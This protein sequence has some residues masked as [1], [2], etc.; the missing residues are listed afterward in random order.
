M[1]P[2]YQV[3][4]AHTYSATENKDF[5]SAYH[6]YKETAIYRLLLGALM[7]GTFEKGPL[8]ITVTS[9]FNHFL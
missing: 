3:G 9:H 6:R 7:C 1:L 5:G 4:A 8:Y 2:V